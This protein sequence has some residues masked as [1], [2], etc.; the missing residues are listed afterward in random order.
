MAEK[1][2]GN[3]PYQNWRDYSKSLFIYAENRIVDDKHKLPIG[4]DF[5]TWFGANLA[6]LEKDQYIRE[7]NTLIAIELLNLFE[8]NTKLWVA[9]KYFN[10]WDTSESDDI[11]SNFTKWLEVVPAEI[12]PCVVKLIDVFKAKRNK[13]DTH[14]NS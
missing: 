5:H 10:T 3:P 2:E 14:T 7:S 9:M 1:W 11:F 8:E 4:L 12:K 13:T 6:D